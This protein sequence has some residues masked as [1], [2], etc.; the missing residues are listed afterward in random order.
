LSA[1]GYPK[2]RI[3][4]WD[5]SLDGVKAAGYRPGAEAYQLL[6]VPP[7]VGY[8][9]KT[10]FS[11]PLLG[12]LIW[13]DLDYKTDRGKVPLLSDQA[14]ES[15]QSHFCSIVSNLVT[16]IINVP[17]LCDN[18]SNGIAGC[19][20][21]TTIPN[22][23]NWRRFGQSGGFGAGAIAEIYSNPIIQK[24]VVLNIMDG[25][26]AQYAGGPE[27]QPNYAV[28]LEK[29]FTSKDPVALDSVAL[30][31]LEKL[32]AKAK[33]PPIGSLAVHVQAAEQMG[34][35]VAEPGRIEIKDVGR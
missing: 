28:H 14:N 22:V 19:L 24:K 4:V 8:D 31:E 27:G 21:N 18:R 7:T 13:G 25:L 12:K 17:V 23:D 3:I 20:Y 26:L 16:K 32:R 35:G 5:R 30:R 11:A 9:A 6:A 29:I 1:A 2:N 10:A 15:D 34:L 33:F